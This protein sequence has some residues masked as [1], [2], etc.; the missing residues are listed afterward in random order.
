MK[1]IDIKKMLDS[2]TELDILKDICKHLELGYDYDWLRDL[3]KVEI[4]GNIVQGTT[5]EMYKLVYGY[6]LKDKEVRK[7][8]YIAPSLKY[9]IDHVIF[10]TPAT[11][12][13]W[14][15]GTKTV[16]KCQKGEEYDWEKGLALCFMKKALG[17]KSNFNNTLNFWK[18]IK[19][20]WGDGK[21]QYHQNI[22]EDFYDFAR[23]HNKPLKITIEQGK[24]R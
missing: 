1:N 5:H 3:F 24:K 2:D 17:N 14:K 15:D 12:V 4:N 16:V 18:P 13:F 23:F 11:I 10:N 8:V 7:K 22:V 19:E 21:T 6:F 9:E 20:D